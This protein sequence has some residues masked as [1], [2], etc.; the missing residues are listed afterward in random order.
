MKRVFVI[1]QYSK[2]SSPVVTCIKE[3][4]AEAGVEL[5][6][7]FQTLSGTTSS[8]SFSLVHDIFRDLGSADLVIADVSG[9][10]PNIMYELG[11]AHGKE[12][13]VLIIRDDVSDQPFD[14]AHFYTLIYDSNRSDKAFRQKLVKKIVQAIQHPEQFA[15]PFHPAQNAN[16]RRPTVFISY[17]HNDRESLGRLRVH[18]RPL[19]R[20]NQIELWDDTRIVAG[21]RWK[22]QI[23]AALERAAIAVLLISA[24][25]LASDFVVN[26]ELP[27]LLKAAEERGTTI[28]PLVLKPCRFMRDVNLSVF[29]AINDP[30]HPL[31]TLNAG[32][33]EELYARLA[34]R[35]ENELNT[36]R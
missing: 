15:S 36:N 31:L 26:N 4:V 1:A 6:E 10:R 24:D 9:V 19:E 20:E 30:R 28:L 5:H 33:Q 27:P 18:L 12:K 16:A 23:G 14:L 21:A 29:Q 7:Q 8:S 35:I 3:A 13:P 11:L 34:E 32:E 2:E 22:E 17:S 25:F